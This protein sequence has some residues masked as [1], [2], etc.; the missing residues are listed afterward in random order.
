M[1]EI[2]NL[3]LGPFGTLVLSLLIL[4]G[5]WKRWWVFG[6]HY[7][8]TVEEKNEWK[9]AALRGTAIAERVVTIHEADSKERRDAQ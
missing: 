9:E 8:E 2:L 1:D 4:F 3:L 6:W 7:R 5:G